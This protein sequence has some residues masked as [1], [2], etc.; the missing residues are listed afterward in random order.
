MHAG[1]TGLAEIEGLKRKIERWRQGRPKSLPMP[2]ELWREATAAAGRLGT[3]V[4]R[5]RWGWA[6]WG[7]SS[8]SCQKGAG[9]RVAMPREAA[10]PSHFIELS[11]PVLGSVGGEGLVVEM[12][13]PDGARLTIRAREASPG[14]LAVIRAF[15]GRS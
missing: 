12:V 5:V 11:P 3:A 15:R 10:P 6:T 9:R 1:I 4:W 8:G 14:V 7:S 2:E 13:T